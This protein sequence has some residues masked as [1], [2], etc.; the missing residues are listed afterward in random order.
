MI[1]DSHRRDDLLGIEED[2]ERALDR[3]R[4]LD[5]RAGLVDA[6]DALG[7]ARIERI[8]ANQVVVFG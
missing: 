7:Q 8:G 6:L 3:Y 5:R 1:V 2:R 4:R